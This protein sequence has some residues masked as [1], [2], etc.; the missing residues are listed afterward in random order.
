MNLVIKVNK[1][2]VHLLAKFKAANMKLAK[3]KL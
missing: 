3:A 2:D 1:L